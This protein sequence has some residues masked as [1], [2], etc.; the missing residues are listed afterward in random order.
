MPSSFYSAIQNHMLR[1]LLLLLITCAG[2]SVVIPSVTAEPRLFEAL[3]GAELRLATIGW[4]LSAANVELCD[5]TEPG[6]GFQLHTLDQYSGSYR[7]AAQEHFK[8]RT[9]VAVSAVIEGS[10]AHAAGIQAD[11]S[12]VR[13]GP[14]TIATVSGRA[15]STNA[16]VSIYRQLAALLPTGD[17]ALEL[18]R[19]GKP[20]SATVKTIP[21]CKTR[22]EV[23]FGAH[24]K[25]SA[26][27]EIVQI[28]SPFI[29]Q[30]PERLVAAV[31]AHELAHNIL[32]HRI[33]LNQH[34]VA[35][36]MLSGVGRNVKFFRE[37]ELEA[38]ILSIYLLTNAGYPSQASLD[39]WRTYGPAHAGGILRSRSHPAWQD[40]VA[41]LEREAAIIAGTPKRPI[42][43]MILT[44]RDRPLSGNWEALLVRAP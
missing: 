31:T 27:G 15:G 41:T 24:W 8:F 4:R 13:I 32:R 14:V 1:K 26:D 36:G 10:P 35:F 33:R 5:Q 16:L 40:R 12:I 37:S 11:D 19:D 2:F 44:A 3:R 6:F 43:P 30:Y 20:I 38:D 39:F 23:V 25:A 29:E 28:G 42:T 22:Y 18:L 34:G 7:S 21:V 9:K 17:V